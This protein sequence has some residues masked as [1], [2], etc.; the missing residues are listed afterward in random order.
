MNKTI[1]IRHRLNREVARAKLETAS[2]KH[3]KQISAF[4]YDMVLH[5]DGWEAT[6]KFD[7]DGNTTS[8]QLSILPNCLKYEFTNLPK[9]GR[10]KLLAFETV[11]KQSIK[12]LLK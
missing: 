3:E 5:E 7:Y 12:S 11:F 1:V 4:M 6:F 10:L 2:Q 9:L 8:V